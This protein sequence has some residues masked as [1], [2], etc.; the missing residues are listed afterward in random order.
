MYW[1][2]DILVPSLHKST[3]PQTDIQADGWMNKQTDALTWGLFLMGN[4]AGRFRDISLPLPHESNRRTDGRMERQTERQTDPLTWGLFLIGNEAGIFRDIS[5]PSL[6][7]S[8]LPLLFFFPP[9]LSR[10]P[11][12]CDC[13]HPSLSFNYLKRVQTHSIIDHSPSSFFLYPGYFT[14]APAHPSSLLLAPSLLTLAT[15]RN[16][17]STLYNC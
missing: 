9:P 3:L 14:H 6:Q 7:E 12:S 8:K 15:V 10:S 2:R 4:A 17:L 16:P 13:P 5:L 11:D 1:I